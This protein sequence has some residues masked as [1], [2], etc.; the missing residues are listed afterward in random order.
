MSW[1][2]SVGIVLLIGLS[3]CESANLTAITW[4]HKINSH[5]SLKGALKSKIAYL[6]HD[7]HD[8]KNVTVP[9]I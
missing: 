3:V 9:F 7:W 4:K 5:K 2:F 8:E 1:I 6:Q